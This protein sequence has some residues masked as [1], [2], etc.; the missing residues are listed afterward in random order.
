MTRTC[1]TFVAGTTIITKGDTFVTLYLS[2]KAK[3]TKQIW[4]YLIMNQWT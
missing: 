3:T 1:F 4:L 2:W